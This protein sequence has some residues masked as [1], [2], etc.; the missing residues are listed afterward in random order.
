MGQEA[1][2]LSVI[3][4]AT[5]NDGRTYSLEWVLDGVLSNSG[6]LERGVESLHGED[7]TGSGQVGLAGDQAGGTEVGA[8]ANVLNDGGERDEALAVGVVRSAWHCG[9]L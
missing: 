7:G 5:L 8:G 1:A 9:I 6:A 2:R 4:R 3:F